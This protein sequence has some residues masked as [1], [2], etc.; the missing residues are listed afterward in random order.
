MLIPCDVFMQLIHL[1]RAI[2][3][4]FSL[5][6]RYLTNALPKFLWSFFKMNVL[7]W[8]VLVGVTTFLKWAI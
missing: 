3:N 5:G 1:H 6:L 4:R 8:N 7:Y 2:K